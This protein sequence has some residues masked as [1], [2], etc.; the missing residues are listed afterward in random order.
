MRNHAVTICAR[1]TG[2]LRLPPWF[3]GH[4]SRFSEL[5]PSP[6]FIKDQETEIS[7]FESRAKNALRIVA[8]E[9]LGGA[10]WG[11][12]WTLAEGKTPPDTLVTIG[13]RAS[14][15]AEALAGAKSEIERIA[16]LDR[17]AVILAGNEASAPPWLANWQ[18]KGATVIRGDCDVW[19]L[20]PHIAT[21]HA[22]DDEIGL[23]ALL[24]GKRVV[25][26]VAAPY[27]GWGL[28]DDR[29]GAP[30]RG[31]NLTLAELFAR[32]TMI[33]TRY[34]DP[35]D[36]RP[37]EIET[38]IDILRH[39]RRQYRINREIAVCVGMSFWK[40]QRIGQF[41]RTSAG[42]P[43]F[44]NRPEKAIAIA[45]SRQSGLA[46]WASR[47]P[48]ALAALAEAAGVTI[49]RV[50]DGFIRSS[51]LGADFIPPASITLDPLGLYYDPS[52]PSGLERILDTIALTTAE[53]HRTRALIQTVIRRNVT[54][55]ASA[56]TVA[57]TAPNG[58]RLILVPGQVENDR[59]V[60]LG[61]G[62]TR[63]NLDLLRRV[64]AANPDAHIV[65]KPHPDVEAGHRPGAIEDTETLRHAD[66][67]IRGGSMA[68]LIG[69][70]DE[71]HCLTSL[72]GFE[73]LL[74]GKAVT[75]YG[76]PF[77]AGW[78]LTTDMAPVPRRHRRLTVE[79]LVAAT[80]LIYPR[81]IDPLTEIPC[82]PEVLIA[83]LAEQTLWRPTPLVRLRRLQGRIAHF[84]R[85]LKTNI[86]AKS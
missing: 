36:G 59:S 29:P 33:R 69:S 73:A 75:V 84:F 4:A 86:R 57:I 46:V 61:G 2:I 45:R 63:G 16:P 28:T 23:L 76:Q 20:F 74:R 13:E 49:Y 48:A 32:H 25:C 40:R 17:V 14:G 78:G 6:S 43:A 10:W 82:P 15:N 53:I 35:Y 24:A 47:E 19:T 83:R 5:E 42:I 7:T 62:E 26:H 1:T 12:S 11:Q 66:Q 9:G 54:K 65:Y 55:Y 56:G 51:G 72:A 85:L 58:R 41:L 70:C 50:E 3:G 68:E 37:C 52:R 27:S 77:Y 44:T 80:L 60:L 18:D 21:V 67:I 22:L 30:P 34:N 8:D 64:R 39:C 38:A 81:Y 31:R 71:V 79:E